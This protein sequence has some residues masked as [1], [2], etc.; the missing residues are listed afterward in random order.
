MFINSR[1]SRSMFRESSLQLINEEKYIFKGHGSMST[2]RDITSIAI[3]QYGEQGALPQSVVC[4]YSPRCIAPSATPDCASNKGCDNLFQPPH[5]LWARIASTRSDGP[6]PM[7]CRVDSITRAGS[8][9]GM[10]VPNLNYPRSLPIF[11]PQASTFNPL[12]ARWK[13]DLD[14]GM[15]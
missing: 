3:Y 14:R 13:H 6:K 8:R 7:G 15:Q 10:S 4:L 11:H 9:R 12:V 5:A 1:C 2:E